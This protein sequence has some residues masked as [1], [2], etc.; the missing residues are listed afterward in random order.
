MASPKNPTLL[1]QYVTGGDRSLKDWHLFLRRVTFAAAL[2]LMAASIVS[3]HWA[4]QLIGLWEPVAWVVPLAMECG[5]AAVA[6]TATT[7]RKDPKPG[8]E[9]GGYYISLWVIFSF[10]MLL[11]QGSNIGHA[12]V[13]VANNDTL[14]PVIPSW[15]VYTFACV[16]AALFPLGGTLFVHVSGFLR[17]HGTGARW[18]EDDAE[19]VYVQAAPGQAA[20]PARAPRPAPARTQPAPARA[21]ESTE[22]APRADAPA[23]ARASSNTPEQERARVVF[24]RMVLERPHERPDAAAMHKAADLTCNP[25]TSRRWRN[26]WWAEVEGQFGTPTT[27]PIVAQVAAEQAPAPEVARAS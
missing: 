4:C 27:D 7:I 2:V 9:T 15:I 5:M 23:P 3:L 20:Q 8:Q 13:T 26:E 12:L 10:V 19:V 17:A 18:I 11:A 16:F 22:R 21:P 6:S 24:D 14:P 1:A 25:A